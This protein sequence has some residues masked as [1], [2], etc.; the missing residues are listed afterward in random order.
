M[1]AGTIK[2]TLIDGT[3][4]ILAQATDPAGNISTD[5]TTNELTLT[6]ANFIAGQS[7]TG[8]IYLPVSSV[9]LTFS[10][11]MDAGS[12]TLADDLLSFTGPDGVDLTAQ[13]SSSNWVN[14]HLLRIDFVTQFAS[15]D[16][17]LVFGR[18][19]SRPPVWRWI[20]I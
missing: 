7:P 10:R 2:P 11:V 14:D 18:P 12:F 16:Y 19:D 9:D 6:V 8:I 15:G 13:V 5:S 17:S 3:Y 20:R 1:P 4:D